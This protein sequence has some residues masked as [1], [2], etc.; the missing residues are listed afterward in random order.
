MDALTRKKCCGFLIP[1]AIGL[2]FSRTVVAGE[3]VTQTEKS[4]PAIQAAGY[5][6]PP[7]TEFRIGIP[8]WLAS[9]NG[10]FGVRGF[11]TQQDVDVTE[12]LDHLD[13][14]VSGS[15]YARYHRWEFLADGQY[16]KLHDTAELEGLKS[17]FFNSVRVSLKD[18]L[19]EGFV[20]YRLLNCEQG[21][22]SLRAGARYNYS[23]G[24]LHLRPGPL[25]RGRRA[26]DSNEWI[27][28]VVG[29]AGRWRVWKPFSVWFESDVGG[30]DVNSDT[31]FRLRREGL[32]VRR[33]TFSGSDWSYQAQ[34]GIELQATR[35]LWTQVGWR[36]LKY[37]YQSNGATNQTAL[38]GPFAQTGINF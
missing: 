19:A 30:F 37:D 5:Q 36:Y 1:F 3:E 16:L 20:G 11:V 13:T 23:S 10:A 31:T 27:D 26:S 32:G 9:V 4:S 21:F 18:A 15:L 28:P 2:V 17:L 34:G 7:D 24:D 12:I 22:L 29:L 14:I 25:L 8:G 35:W 33:D 6:S 38:S